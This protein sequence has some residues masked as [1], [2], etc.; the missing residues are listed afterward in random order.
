MVRVRE[1]EA[2]KGTEPCARESLH[3]EPQYRL[4]HRTE[5]RTSQPHRRVSL[6][7]RDP[8]YA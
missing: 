4:T 6:T 1:H 5:L 2:C 8:V 7:G 3:G